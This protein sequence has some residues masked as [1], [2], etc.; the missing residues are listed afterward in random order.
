M[1]F[2]DTMVMQNRRGGVIAPLEGHRALCTLSERL[3]T[4]LTMIKFAAVCPTL[5]I[6]LLSEMILKGLRRGEGS[7]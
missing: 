4:A 3:A 1:L 7:P 5:A 6:L 2:C